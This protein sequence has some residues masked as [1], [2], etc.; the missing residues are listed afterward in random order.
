[1]VTTEI[2]PVLS[3][4]AESR[5]YNRI[6]RWLGLTDFVLGFG[7]LVVLLAT[8]WTGWLRDLAERIAAQNYA[9]AV[10][11]YVLMLMIISKMLGT[12]LD[13]YGFRLEH[14]YNLSNQR[15]RSWLWDECK[16][17]LIGLVMATVVVELLYMLMRQTPEHWWVVAWI[18]FLGLVVLLAQLAPVVL[19]PIF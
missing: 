4:S 11:F 19:F 2:T 5:R 12:P 7:L 6:K 14:R 13:Y 1:M 17:F 16:G 8:G 9:F 10:F 3:D 18:I 15:L